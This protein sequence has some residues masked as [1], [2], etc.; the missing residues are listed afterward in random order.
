[1]RKKREEK[2]EEGWKSKRT[3]KSKREKKEKRGNTVGF[4]FSSPYFLEDG[5]DGETCSTLTRRAPAYYRKGP[6]LGPPSKLLP[7]RK[8]SPSPLS[9]ET[10]SD[11]V[12]SER[13]G[14]KERER[15]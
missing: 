7:C 12:D 6:S 4:L 2:K 13:R 9:V 10:S 8:A 11:E 5:V 1:M 3:K 14:K 15:R